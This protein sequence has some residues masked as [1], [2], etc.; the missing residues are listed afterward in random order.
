M[1]ALPIK[2]VIVGDRGVGKTCLV[3]AWLEGKFPEECKPTIMDT[4][5]TKIIV[6]GRDELLTLYDTSGN[7]FCQIRPLCYPKTNVFV[8]CYAID[9]RSSFENITAKW[10]KEVRFHCKDVPIILVATKTDLRLETA[11]ATKISNEEGLRLALTIGA[12]YYLECSAK[13]KTSAH[14]VFV[15]AARAARTYLSSTSGDV[16]EVKKKTEKTEKT[17][18]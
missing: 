18:T 8:L 7:D 11:G 9:N 16:K 6:D 12:A 3:K 2:C 15:N 10:I 1:E 13:Q 17:V 4:Y 5:E 14:E